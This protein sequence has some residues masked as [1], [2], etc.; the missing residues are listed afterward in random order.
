LVAGAVALLLAGGLAIGTTLT[1]V[2][3][4]ND[5]PQGNDATVVDYGSTSADAAE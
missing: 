5:T 2:N 4:V 1:L 3:A